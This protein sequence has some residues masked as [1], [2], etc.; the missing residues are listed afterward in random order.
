MPD[1][2]LPPMRTNR[3]V[4]TLT[5]APWVL[6]AFMSSNAEAATQWKWRDSTGRV[7]Y[8]DRPP[9]AGT[10]D[11]NILVRP[12][13]ARTTTPPLVTPVASAPATA[14]KPSVKA[15]DPELEARKRKAD[16]EKAA[17]QKAAEDK[18]AQ[19]RAD[20]CQRAQAYQR[21]LDDGMRIARTN[22]KGEREVMDDQARAQEQVRNRQTI[23]NNC[24]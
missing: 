18:Q 14:P 23:A 5:L 2:K 7:Q 11:Q 8:S 24:Q 17:Q 16:E 15:S 1:A 4:L 6:A 20:N 13:G 9:P 21:S 12:A 10:P 22:A 19:V 3:L